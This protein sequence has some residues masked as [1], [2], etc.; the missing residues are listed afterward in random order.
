MRSMI[1]ATAIS[2]PEV[3]LPRVSDLSKWAVIACDQFTAQPDYWEQL[4]ELVGDAPSTLNF[5]LPEVWLEERLDS[6]PADIAAAMDKAVANQLFDNV[7]GYVL[8]ERT[9]NSGAKRIGLIANIA[10]TDYEYSPENNARIK[11]TEATVPDRLPPRA[12]IRAAAP[13]EM[14]HVLVLLNDP[15]HQII[16]ALYQRRQELELEQLYDFELNMNGGH[17]K[18]WLVPDT[19][20]FLTAD[21]VGL[22]RDGVLALVGDGN[23]SLAAAKLIGDTSALVELVN[24]HSPAIEFE[25][26]HRIVIGAGQD[27][28]EELATW[29]SKRLNTDTPEAFTKIYLAGEMGEI[30]IPANPADAIADV[31]QFIDEYAKEHD[32][33]VDYIH[34]DKELIAI[35]DRL[36]DNDEEAVAIFLPAIDKN[37]LFDYTAR[38]GVLPRKSF[39][40]GHAEDKRY[41]LELAFRS[42]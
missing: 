15:V 13:L 10:L 2:A 20:G 27:F 39:S 16:E 11:A 35:A 36:A 30:P 12:A 8:V 41:Y 25:P 42:A 18:G 19:Y 6:A 33:I 5:I 24:I 26:I 29:L 38:R 40:I 4:T 7:D 21:L 28:A 22:E 3:L 17:L 9:L 1:G 31:Q 32:V 34:G 37:T 23:H 14:P